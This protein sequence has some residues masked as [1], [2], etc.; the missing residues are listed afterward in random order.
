MQNATTS[1]WPRALCRGLAPDQG[2][3]DCGK[4]LHGAPSPPLIV[5]PAYGEDPGGRSFGV[6]RHQETI[7][8]PRPELLATVV[9]EYALRTPIIQGNVKPP[10]IAL[11]ELGKKDRDVEIAGRMMEFDV[12]K[13]YLRK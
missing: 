4:E 11:E 7:K 13:C 3:A 9:L 5:R 8:I 12:D 2:H 10:F 6:Y 1:A